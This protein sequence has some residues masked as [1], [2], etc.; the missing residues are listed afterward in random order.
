MSA[1]TLRLSHAPRRVTAA[2]QERWSRP[3]AA[4]VWSAVSAALWTGIISMGAA[5]F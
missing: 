1:L 2:T 5:L 4:L 3:V